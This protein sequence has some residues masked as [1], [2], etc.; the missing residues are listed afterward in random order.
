MSD[1]IF[2]LKQQLRKAL[3]KQRREQDKE[4][5]AIASKNICGKIIELDRFNDS[6]TI[7]AYM[8]SKGEVDVGELVSHART[9]GKR[10]AFPL[11]VDDGGL[12]L[13]VPNTPASFKIGAYGI[14]EPDES[15]S[16]EI[17]VSQIDMIIV[18]A[19]AF[20]RNGQRLGQG[21][22]YYDRLLQK[23]DAYTIGVGFD[24][25]LLDY[26]PL[27]EH[28][29]SLDCIVTPTELLAINI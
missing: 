18:P 8:C 20:T 12:R 9:C 23:S 6:D 4:V 2:E 27:E 26:L 21:G 10:I 22:G 1:S 29:R 13:L 24:F 25:Q 3:R 28:D 5:A 19:V 11:C 7:L 16:I 15:D 14:L 17:D